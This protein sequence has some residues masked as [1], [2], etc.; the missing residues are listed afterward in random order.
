MMSRI[1]RWRELLHLIEERV[2]VPKVSRRRSRGPTPSVAQPSQAHEEP[3]EPVPPAPVVRLLQ[4]AR[5]SESGRFD[6][7]AF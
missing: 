1:F 2:L 3:V 7:K 5:R 4:E 6:I